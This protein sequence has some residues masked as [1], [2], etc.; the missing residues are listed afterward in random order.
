MPLSQQ[1]TQILQSDEISFLLNNI[2]QN[3]NHLSKSEIKI[4]LESLKE[5]VI[6]EY[7]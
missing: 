2:I 5:I 7:Y 3:I 1:T 6:G 4:K